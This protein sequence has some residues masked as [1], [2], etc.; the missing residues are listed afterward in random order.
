MSRGIPNM[1]KDRCATKLSFRPENPYR[2]GEHIRSFFL[3]TEE[4]SKADTDSP[5]DVRLIW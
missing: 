2:N 3:D 1:N 5:Q 4:Q